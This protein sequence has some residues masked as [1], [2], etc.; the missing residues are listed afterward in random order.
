MASL[1]AGSGLEPAD[2]A[3]LH[4]KDPDRER[5]ERAVRGR[6]GQKDGMTALLSAVID[7]RE[8]PLAR[9][10]A[11]HETVIPKAAQ[12]DAGGELRPRTIE[13]PGSGPR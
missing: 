7:R 2:R 11:L 10:H 9:L 1:L 13:T 12:Q 8:A 3:T 6:N 5:R 4:R